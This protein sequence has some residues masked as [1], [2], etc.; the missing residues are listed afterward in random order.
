[1]GIVRLGSALTPATLV[2]GTHPIGANSSFCVLGTER[3][4]AYSTQQAPFRHATPFDG[5][6]FPVRHLRDA[7]NGVAAHAY[8]YLALHFVLHAVQ[9][10]CAGKLVRSLGSRA[11]ASLC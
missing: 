4:G 3:P 2:H 5:T 1:M 11:A 8:A 7:A 10:V 6:N 9:Q